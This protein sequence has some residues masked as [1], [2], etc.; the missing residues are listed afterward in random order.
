M[1]SRTRLPLLPELLFLLVLV[2]ALACGGEAPTDEGETADAEYAERISTEHE[3]DTPEA[4]PATDGAPTAAEVVTEDVVYANLDGRDVTGYLARPA[5]AEA[6]GPAI[7]VIQ[8]WWGLNDNIRAMARKLAGEG[9]TALAV[10]LYEGQ[11]AEDRDGARALVTA[12]M[13][14]ADELA[15]N[16]RQ[17]HGYLKGQGATSI[18]SIGWCFG[19]GWSLETALMLGDELD[20]AVIYYGR[21]K[22]EASELEPLTAPVL[23]IFG[24]ED[25]G[26][27]V[28]GVRAFEAALGELGKT[29]SIHVYEGADHAFANPSGTRYQAEA[30]EDAWAKTLDFFG[31]HL[32]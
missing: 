25:Q 31:E 8:E 18:G 19:G 28:D 7:L 1:E 9:Y 14:K 12:A 5:D 27:P 29:A 32:G 26:I 20:A 24:A 21:V 17:A 10:D 11:V 3:G 30:A 23:G 22:T 6:G 2:T 13:E 15:D 4:N 16:L